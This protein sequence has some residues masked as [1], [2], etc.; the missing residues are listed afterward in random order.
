LSLGGEA[1][2]GDVSAF[3]GTT[4]EFKIVN[5]SRNIHDPLIVDNFEFSPELVPEPSTLALT[6]LGFL[7]LALGCRKRSTP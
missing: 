6:V 3:A 1:Y 4:T 5:T 7:S 2:A